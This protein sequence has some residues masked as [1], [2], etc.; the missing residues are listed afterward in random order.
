MSGGHRAIVLSERERQA[1]SGTHKLS[2]ALMAAA[3][4]LSSFTNTDQPV[5]EFAAPPETSQ[6]AD[7][8][9][10]ADTNVGGRMKEFGVENEVEA[11]NFLQRTLTKV[12]QKV[13]KQPQSSKNTTI[14]ENARQM[15]HILEGNEQHVEATLEITDELIESMIAVL[16]EEKEI[17]EPAQTETDSPQQQTT[18]NPGQQSRLT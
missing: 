3:V 7:T 13:S 9:P 15:L 1:N 14:L 4:V 8:T 5:L 18:P 16:E 2:T 17:H 10:V 6:G 11:K 12:T